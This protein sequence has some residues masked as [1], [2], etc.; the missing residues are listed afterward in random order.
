M[1]ISGKKHYFTL[2]FRLGQSMDALFFNLELS[3]GHKS[4]C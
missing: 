2:E 1:I 4:C 3:Y